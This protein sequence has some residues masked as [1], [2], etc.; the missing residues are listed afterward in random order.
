MI[1]FNRGYMCGVFITAG[2]FLIIIGYIIDSL[3]PGIYGVLC[4]LLSWMKIIGLLDIKEYWNCSTTGTR[5]SPGKYIQRTG[6]FHL[7]NGP[8]M[9]G[10]RGIRKFKH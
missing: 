4:I 9:I 2:I 6:E 10:F 3:D 8:I 7:V 5:W 1:L